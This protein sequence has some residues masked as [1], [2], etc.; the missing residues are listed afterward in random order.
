MSSN[1]LPERTKIELDTGSLLKAIAIVIGALLLLSF[2]KI[3]S[4]VLTLIFIALFLAVAL[5]PAVSFI[6]RRLKS[7]S[8]VAATGIAYLLVTIFLSGFF[9]LVIPPLFNQTVDYIKEV[10]A[11]IRS[12]QESN[13]TVSQLIEDSDLDQQIDQFADDFK[14]QFRNVGEPVLS[15]AGRVG[16]VVI[17]TITVFVLTFMMLVEGPAWLKRFFDAMPVGKREKRKKVAQRMY[18]QVTGYVNGQVL[19]ASIAGIFAFVGL[20]IASS[21]FSADINE[22]ALAAIVALFALLPLIGATL[23]AIIVIFACLLVSFP[24]ALTMI[25][26][27]IIYQQIENVTIQP[28]IQSRSSN[29]TPLIVFISALIGVSLGGL[30][31]AFVAIPLAGIIRIL[32]EE[33]YL[34][35]TAAPS[36]GAKTKQTR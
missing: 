5:N 6:A 27:F 15:T 2:V 24:L 32:L 12:F 16:S 34:K 8:R 18:G 23:G 25:V 35:N 36:S 19:V 7:Q 22:V 1:K 9:A 30:I 31:G 21:I 29:L 14:N 10:P 17:S 26:F 28:L 4:H 13:T 33:Y 11:T 20:V 3:I